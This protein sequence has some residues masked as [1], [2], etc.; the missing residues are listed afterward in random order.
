MIGEETYE[1]FL[2]VC[3][4]DESAMLYLIE[5]WFAEKPGIE[6]IAA[7]F[8]E[9][10]RDYAALYPDTPAEDFSVELRRLRPRDNHRPSTI[11]FSE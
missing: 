1:L 5:H 3:E 9:A 8:E 2:R 6:T 11:Q 4:S 7:L 10:K